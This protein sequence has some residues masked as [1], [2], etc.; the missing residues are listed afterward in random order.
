MKKNAQRF[1]L[2]QL[3]CQCKEEII[4]KTWSKVNFEH[5]FWKNNLTLKEN[6]FIQNLNSARG[7]NFLLFNTEYLL[8]VKGLQTQN[9]ICLKNLKKS[10]IIF[11]KY[12]K[13][14][15]VQ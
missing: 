15:D 13:N 12:D 11:E 7:S 10:T 2:C 9:W 4:L 5:F 14:I 3:P 8:K 1:K 6:F